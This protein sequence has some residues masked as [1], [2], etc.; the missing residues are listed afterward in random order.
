MKGTAFDTTRLTGC[1]PHRILLVVQHS[2]INLSIADYR[3]RARVAALLRKKRVQ[4]S[5]FVPSQGCRSSKRQL[6]FGNGPLRTPHSRTALL[7]IR[8]HAT[9]VTCHQHSHSETSK[10]TAAACCCP[11]SKLYLQRRFLP[12][13]LRPNIGGGV[14]SSV[15][16][17]KRPCL[18][19]ENTSGLYMV[20]TE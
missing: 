12:K 2:D 9:T 4:N 5:E 11:H 19:A 3:P 14:I 10:S 17:G 8:I 6:K 1:A 16:A 7:C 13:A 15:G 18:P 20:G